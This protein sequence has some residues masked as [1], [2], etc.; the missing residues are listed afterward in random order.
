VKER[1]NLPIWKLQLKPKIPV[2]VFKDKIS[3]IF[4]G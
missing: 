3:L 2:S 4:L 1:K